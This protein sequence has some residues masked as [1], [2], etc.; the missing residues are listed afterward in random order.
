M[1]ALQYLNKYFVKYKWKMLLG[2][3]ITALARV[4]AVYVPRFVG[5]ATDLITQYI[6]GDIAGKSTF[7]DQLLHNILLIFGAALI[8][9]FFTFLMR[10]TF[11]MVSRSIE[12]DL[13]NEVYEQYQNLSLNFYKKNRT[14]DLMN[15]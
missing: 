10:Q 5:N 1:K 12:Y 13:K 15:R 6:Q 4:F 11:I 14:G 3:V 9:A 2:L 7:N 8:A